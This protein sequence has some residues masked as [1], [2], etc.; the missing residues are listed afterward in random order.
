MSM[1]DRR[2]STHETV[3]APSP[4]H[5]L[6]LNQ[7]GNNRGDESALRAMLAGIENQSEL[8]VAFTVLHQFAEAD[9]DLDVP[10]RTRWISLVPS[11][12]EAARMAVFVASVLIGVRW[13]AVLGRWGRSV[14]DAC[15]E[16]D[17]AVS[18]PGGPYFGDL[19]AGHELLHWFYVWLADRF[20]TPLM[21]YAP[22]VG[23]FDSQLLN[24]LRRRL[25][26]RFRALTVRESISLEH[27]KMLLGNANPL[28]ILVTDAALQRPLPP[29]DRQEYFGPRRRELA[30]HFLIGVSAIAWRYPHHSNP[31]VAQAEYERV[32]LDAML[33][34]HACRKV[35]FLLVPQLYGAAHSDVPYL[36]RLAARL[37]PEV[38]WELVDP[39]AN[40]DYQQRLFGMVDMY[41]TSRY[42][43]QIFA[44]SN[45]VPGV[46]IYYEHKALGFLRQLGLERLAF[47]IDDLNVAHVTSAIDEVLDRHR[48]LSDLIADAVP[49]L[50]QLSAQSSKL[51][52]SIL[53][54]SSPQ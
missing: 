14:V 1:G 35:H 41:F 50:R 52:V 11:F 7:H 40:S 22:S 31:A 5:V 37:P 21:L 54:R 28:P 47:P 46:C 38:S 15:R 2:K 26:Q 32:V 10:Q 39:R 16:A 3:A 12:W 8:P 53:S 30:D 51:V 42:H 34:L 25:F 20:G 4:I 45:A 17:I 24:P 43:P 48:E 19:Y 29:L 27:L 13:R 49:P 18:A 44:I 23:P 33:H 36:Q 9:V 6:V